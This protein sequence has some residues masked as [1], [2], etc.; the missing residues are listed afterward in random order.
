MNPTGRRRV[1]YSK[2]EKCESEEV[3]K[4][5][6]QKKISNQTKILN[7]CAF[8]WN[9]LSNLTLN[10]E[11]E[12]CQFTSSWTHSGFVPPDS[13][14]SSHSKEAGCDRQGVQLK[15]IPPNHYGTGFLTS[16]QPFW[17]NL[18]KVVAFM[19]IIHLIKAKVFCFRLLQ[20]CWLVTR[21][22]KA[23]GER[24]H[25]NARMFSICGGE[26]CHIWAAQC[27]QFITVRDGG[28]WVKQWFRPPPS[29]HT[30]GWKEGHG[31]QV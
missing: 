26:L 5:A 10:H 4:W 28:T 24:R 30:L 18:L 27:I 20:M 25:W 16:M 14:H 19:L 6:S 9:G 31:R 29:S 13:A 23:I 8:R 2:D 3:T 12:G 11:P 22:W 21:S 7:I 17:A 1:P 15:S